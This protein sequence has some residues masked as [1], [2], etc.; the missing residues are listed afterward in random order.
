MDDAIFKL[1][2]GRRT[3]HE[4]K[5]EAV[6]LDTVKQ[7]IEAARW[8]PNHHLTEPWHFYLLGLETVKSVIDLNTAIIREKSGDDAARD[9]AQRWSKIPGWLVVTC[10]KS[11]DQQQMQEDYAA[12]CC[13]VQNLML[14]LWNENIG[15]KWSTGK[16]TRDPRF[17]DLLWIDPAAETIVG[18]F[19]YGYA[20]EV[21]PAVRKPVS[22]SMV[23][24]P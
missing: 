8:A 5:P 18:L 23:E 4:Y 1:I 12:C 15:V 3:I 20:K 13:A 14:Y 21:P 22:A 2:A 7:A 24:L 10:D 17:Y 6:P 16:V 9:K 11:A 19:W